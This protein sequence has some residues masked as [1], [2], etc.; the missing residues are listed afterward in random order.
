LLLIYGQL[1]QS[2]FVSATR[3]IPA[4]D[5]ENEDKAIAVEV[6]WFIYTSDGVVHGKQLDPVPNLL[7]RF[8]EP[9]LSRSVDWRLVRHQDS[10]L[11]WPPMQPVARPSRTGTAG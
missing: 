6:V 3:L 5:V 8:Q 10:F 7:L 2:R 4:E 1:L 11:L 9:H